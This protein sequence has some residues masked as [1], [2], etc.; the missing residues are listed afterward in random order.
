MTKSRQIEQEQLKDCPFSAC[1]GKAI[2]SAAF[3]PTVTCKECG[4]F[5][6][7]F[8]DLSA[9]EFW[10]SR[11]KP[12]QTEMEDYPAHKH[13]MTNREDLTMGDDGVDPDYLDKVIDDFSSLH[14][15]YQ[16][17]REAVVVLEDGAEPEVG[18]F[19]RVCTYYDNGDILSEDIWHITEQKDWKHWIG[20]GD[21]VELFRRNGKPCIYKSEL[22]ANEQLGEK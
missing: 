4:T 21:S 3:C 19:V 22:E 8:E 17:L 14:R 5:V 15:Q 10:N 2:Y 11:P 1:G 20:R 13:M 12:R 9:I 16:K 18:D 7:A 6:T